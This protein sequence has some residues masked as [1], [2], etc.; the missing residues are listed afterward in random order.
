MVAPIAGLAPPQLAEVP[1][2][3]VWPT[4]GSTRIGRLVGR[5]C[6]SRV[7]WGFFTLG[8]LWAIATIP[9]SL[10][11]FAWLLVPGAARRYRLTNR[12]IV[13]QHGLSGK[14]IRAIGLDEFDAVEEDVLPGQAWLHSG[15]LRFFRSGQEVFR[16][17]GVSRPTV[18]REVCLKARTALLSVREVMR[19]QAEGGRMKREG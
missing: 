11:A 9:L 1:S 17:A 13:V 15:D 5:L 18:F 3:T 12:R 19:Q 6:G 2:M 14:E 7:G 10:A 8:K 4:I 16:L